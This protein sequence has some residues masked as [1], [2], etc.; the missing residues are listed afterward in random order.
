MIDGWVRKNSNFKFDYNGNFAKSGEVNQIILEQAQ[1][2]Y[3]NRL[4]RKNYHLTQMILIF[5][6]QED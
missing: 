6:L 5:R 2:L 4:I 1:E 3:A